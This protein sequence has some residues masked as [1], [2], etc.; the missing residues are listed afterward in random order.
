MVPPNVALEANGVTDSRH[1]L[2]VDD[3][4]VFLA[5]M[6]KVLRQAGYRVTA[7]EHFSAAISALEDVDNK[8]DLLVTDIA[9]PHGVNG[10]ALGRMARIRPQAMPIVSLTGYDF[11][12]IDEQ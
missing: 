12:R 3:A 5:A 11:P 8:P 4:G 7:A 10:V 2:L 1:V 6:A 9:M